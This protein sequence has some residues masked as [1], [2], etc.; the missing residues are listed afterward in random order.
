MFL[1]MLVKANVPPV[2]GAVWLG[3]APPWSSLQVD[4]VFFYRCLKYLPGL[5]KSRALQ[6]ANVFLLPLNVFWQLKQISVF[7]ESLALPV[8]FWWKLEYQ[9]PCWCKLSQNGP[10]QVSDLSESESKPTSTRFCPFLWPAF[11]FISL[12]TNKEMKI[13]NSSQ[14]FFPFTYSYY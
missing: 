6:K 3:A 14:C 7:G 4:D 11:I 9:G 1:T 10:R 12:S 2:G 13:G 8:F 5:V